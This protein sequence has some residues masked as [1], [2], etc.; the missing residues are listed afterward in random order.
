MWHLLKVIPKIDD[1]DEDDVMF[2]FTCIIIIIILLEWSIKD[3]PFIHIKILENVE[4][5][6][7]DTLVG[8]HLDNFLADEPKR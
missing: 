5:T 6:S 7:V 8:R 4:L 1:E 2:C 3:E